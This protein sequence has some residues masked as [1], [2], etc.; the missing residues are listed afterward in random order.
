MAQHN[1]P[2]NCPHPG[3][4]TREIEELRKLQQR[5]IGAP[6]YGHDV[7]SMAVNLG[8]LANLAGTWKGTGFSQ[9]WRP[10]NN[11][12]ASYNPTPQNRFLQLNATRERTTFSV[13]P[14][15]IPNRGVANQ[16]D[17]TIY[18]LHYLQSINDGDPKKFPNHGE[19]LH[20]EPGLF[21]NVPAS[22]YM[23]D[24][25]AVP[26]GNIQP[27]T[28]VR[29]AS[30]PHGVTVMM[31]G[32][33]PSATP[34]A[35]PPFIP[36]IYPIPEL[37]AFAPPYSPPLPAN[38][39]GRGIQPAN[40][41]P[42]APPPP[43]PPPAVP[44]AGMNYPLH[45]VPE[46]IIADDNLGSQSNGPYDASTGVDPVL[47]QRAVD[48]PN[49]LLKDAIAGQDIL[50]HITLAMTSDFA[51]DA[52]NPANVASSIGNIPF[53][54]IPQ[55]ISGIDAHSLAS[56]N[57]IVRSAR[58]TFWLEFVRYPTFGHDRGHGERPFDAVPHGPLHSLTLF[59]G[60]PYY[61]QLQ[62]SQVVILVFN[63]VIWPHITTATLQLTHG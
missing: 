48:N 30:I 42:Y 50:G 60:E 10:D 25:I 13:I 53:L 62:Y 41:P 44:P 45:P 54:G 22:G 57:A 49:A 7:V 40:L 27:A 26:N 14:N 36:D 21:L 39:V 29:L 61:L 18:G 38:G 20:I 59:N 32:P 24:G 12:P 35:G 17:I 4:A 16:P 9:M 33:A 63:K 8:P 52:T 5:K 19:A 51:A 55:L 56:N 6:R 34:V 23:S 2:G 28:I 37:P 11:D 15:A 47:F 46:T 58:A 31:Q 1:T 3:A 43:P